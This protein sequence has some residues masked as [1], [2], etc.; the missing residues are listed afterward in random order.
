MGTVMARVGI[1]YG[2]AA[3]LVFLA[4]YLIAVAGDDNYVFYENYLSDLGV[5]TAAWAFNTGLIFAGA[6]TMAFAV[7]GI[8]QSLR[9][10]ILLYIALAMTVLAGVFLILIGVYTEE[11]E[12][13]HYA[14]TISFFMSFFGALIFYALAFHLTDA[15]GDLRPAFRKGMII[16]TDVA[17]PIDAVMFLI[18]FNP[19]TETISVIIILSWSLAMASTLL[20][21][22]ADADTF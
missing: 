15:T 9:G 12:D 13:I 6:F 16:A 17:L 4:F 2:Y 1:Y 8:G 7:W 21:G 10:G 20:L 11:Q 18:G 14:V 19:Q 5:G 3:P 22:G